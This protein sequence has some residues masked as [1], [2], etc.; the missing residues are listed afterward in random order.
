MQSF[1]CCLVAKLQFEALEACT[2]SPF[3]YSANSYTQNHEKPQA[4]VED[5]TSV[6]EEHIFLQ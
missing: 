1:F 5:L 3:T 2:V 6:T 4:Q